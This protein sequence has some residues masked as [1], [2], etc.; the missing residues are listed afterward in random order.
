MSSATM[1]CSGGACTG[2]YVSV[3]TSFFG[4]FGIAIV[5]LVPYLDGLSLAL[6]LFT[7]YSLYIKK[8]NYLYAPFLCGLVG[9]ICMVIN[10]IFITQ[11]KYL[12]YFGNLLLIVAS[13]WNYKV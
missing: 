2:M 4:A 8:R 13:F 12:L 11:D 7:L 3:L 5:D 10:F 1:V 6:V 9:A